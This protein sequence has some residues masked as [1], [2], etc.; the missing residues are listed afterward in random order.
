MKLISAFILSQDTD[1]YW[2]P[3]A[4]G[5]VVRTSNLLEELGQVS[6]FFFFENLRFH[7]LASDTD[8]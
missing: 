7:E 8:I 4:S 6:F 1:L 2:P 5:L 3:T